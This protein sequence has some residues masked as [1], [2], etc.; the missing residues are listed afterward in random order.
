MSTA[1]KPILLQNASLWRKQW[2]EENVNQPKAHEWQAIQHSLVTLMRQS[3]GGFR[4][5]S[6]VKIMA[7]TLSTQSETSFEF[8]L[9][10]KHL[11]ITNDKSK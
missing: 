7:I 10:K 8:Q 6:P 2:G 3:P 9:E 1:G 11:A 4:I 5:D